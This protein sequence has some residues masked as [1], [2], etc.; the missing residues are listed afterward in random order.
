MYFLQSIGALFA[1]GV[2]GATSSSSAPSYLFYASE[3][4]DACKYL[5][6][7]HPDECNQQ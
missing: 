6:Q 5:C 4:H 1:I 2:A 7:A 3:A